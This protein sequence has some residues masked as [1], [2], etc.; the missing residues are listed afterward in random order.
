[1]ALPETEI[2]NVVLAQLPEARREQSVVY[3]DQRVHPA[4]SDI[5][6]DYKKVRLNARTMVG[7]IDLEPE[8]NWGHPCRYVLVDSESGE[9]RNVDAHFPPFLRESPSN[10]IVLFKGQRVPDWAV[11]KSNQTKS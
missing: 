1:M 2:A 7:F 5:E 11:R 6:I 8:M 3:L 10:L 9:H 4:E